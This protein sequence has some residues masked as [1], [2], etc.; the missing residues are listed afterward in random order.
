MA[1]GRCQSRK[2]K[3]GLFVGRFQPFHYGHGH[4]IKFAL[5]SCDELVIAVGS[6]QESG[7]SRNPLDVATRIGMVKS[8]LDEIGAG[9]PNVKVVAVPDFGA[10]A[11]WFNYISAN[12]DGI[13]AV[14]SGND[15]VKSIFK[16]RGIDVIEP[17]QYRR[18]E[19]SGTNIRGLIK[20]GKEW[21]GLV[22]SVV[23]NLVLEN[24]EKIKKA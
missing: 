5:S 17:P 9:G 14:F 4:A 7:T 13:E 22:P 10:D 1:A 20:D 2:Y 24:K 15:L 3:K 11:E 23:A 8:G 18:E 12:H 21:H 6:A 19:L 16:D